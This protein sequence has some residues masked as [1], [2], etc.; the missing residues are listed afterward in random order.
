MDVVTLRV[1]RVSAP[2]R[3]QVLE[4]LR[5]AITES[6]F[7][8]GDR[9]IERELCELTGVSRTLI[10]EAL[11]QL[12]TLGLVTT[13]PNKGPV[14]TRISPEDAE[15]LYQVRAVLE[16]LASRLFAE[17]ASDEQRRVLVASFERL[18]EAL[19][20]EDP[21]GRLRAKTDFYEAL[22]DGCGN[23]VVRTQ[24]QQ[25]HARIALL[26]AT[27]LSQ[28]G[29]PQQTVV[30]IRRIVEALKRGD[31][32]A[33]WDASVEHVEQAA[34]VAVGALKAMT[35]EGLEPAGTESQ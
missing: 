18:A 11:R 35:E 13:I 26:R 34:I 14:V 28:P 12:E 17:R 32:Q 1:S 29:R 27:S 4:L 20:N 7:R 25:L 19:E 23:Q 16:G 2:L 3:Q 9:L 21:R 8:P 15:E 31:G 24:L 10:R 22:L 6:R 30:E 5:N 33:A